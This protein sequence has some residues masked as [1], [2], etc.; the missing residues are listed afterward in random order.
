MAEAHQLGSPERPL[1]V[2]VVGAGPAGFYTC[3][4]LLK[5]GDLVVEVD[6]FDRL[7]APYGLVRYGVAPDHQKIKSVIKQFE[8]TAAHERFRFLGNVTMGRDISHDE[9]TAHYD[10]VVYSVGAE[11]D[12]RM[13]IPGEDLIG[14]HPATEFVWWY[15]GHPD[16]R[17]HQFDLQAERAVVVGVG[18]VAL[19]I[20]RV[21]LRDTEELGKT[22][23]A[24]HALEQL[25]TS[26]V[27]E[28]LCLGRR[29]PAQ[30]AFAQKELKDIVTK[31]DI[32]VVIDK[33][34]TDEAL[35]TAE[36]LDP[37]YKRKLEYLAKVADEGPKGT[38][39][40][41]VLRFLAS[42]IELIG[43][44]DR[45]RAVKIERNELVKGDDGWVR[46]KGTGD[47]TTVD[48]GSVFRSVGYHGVGLEG[49]PFD[50]KKGVIPNDEGRVLSEPG[51]DVIPDVY[52][53]G[54]IKRGPTG[55][56]G[57]NKTDAV[58]T[59][60]KMLE[61]IAGKTAAPSEQK[62]AAAV[63][64]LLAGRGV[65]VVSYDDWKKLDALEVE[66]GQSLGKVRDKFTSTEDMLKALGG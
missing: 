21:M 42:P 10:H 50:P 61:D 14:S 31:T 11:T 41:L 36:D 66:A 40:R 26:K 27:K 18:D 37:I 19:D 28:V 48:A 49:V 56:I 30:A 38:G 51:G 43:D 52:C 54:W 55:V 2:A 47:V 13:R 23:I 12:R 6:L 3:D 39:K 29:G 44:N 59:V 20:A 57:T 33:A 9:L 32:D 1:R 16:Y 45:V 60:K 24:G 4:D 5:R 35:Q 15:N 7:P 34:Q 53:C 25:S 58:A 63:D 65:R 22:D 17:S 46:P 8:R 62:T 64:A